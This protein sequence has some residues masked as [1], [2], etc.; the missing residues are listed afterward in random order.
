MLSSFFFFSKFRFLEAV[1]FDAL[2][3]P[4]GM[5][6]FYWI[7]QDSTGF[8]GNGTGILRNGPDSSRFRQ[9]GPV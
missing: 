9:K 3:S 1:L 4:A 8:Q 5:H 6:S 7:P 2:R